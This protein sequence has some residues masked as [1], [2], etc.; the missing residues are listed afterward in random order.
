[1]VESVK[2]RIPH[3]SLFQVATVLFDNAKDI[4]QFHLGKWCTFTKGSCLRNYPST[5]TREQEKLRQQYTLVLRNLPYGICAYD[6]I[7]I[8]TDA[9]AVSIGL[10][11]HS[12]SLKNKPWAYFA[13]KS[14]VDLQNAKDIQRSLKGK[15]LLWDHPENVKKFCIRCSSPDHASK[16]CDSIQS[17]GRKPTPK[18]IAAAYKRFNHDVPSSRGH[19]T[20]NPSNSNRRTNSTNRDRSNSRSRSRGRNNNNNN[21]NNNKNKSNNKK[22]Y[23]DVASSSSSFS[24]NN[25]LNASIHA[26]PNNSNN[27]KG[28]DKQTT[29]NVNPALIQTLSTAMDRLEFLISDYRK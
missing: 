21:N 9:G 3:N 19:Y 29:S 22:S 6:L 1:M 23:A 20:R 17:R 12:K 13:F 4:E 11:I 16:E 10:P 7:D 2:T 18:H 28:K 15:E 27:S 25:S 26:P 8:Y 24:S 14:E 5:F